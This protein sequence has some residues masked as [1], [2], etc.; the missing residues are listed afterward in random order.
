MASHRSQHLT[1][2]I[3][4]N[5]E[6]LMERILHYA[7]LHN[8]TAYTSTLMEAWRA[9]ISGLSEAL[10]QALASY[11]NPPE[12]G[13]TEDWFGDPCGI[14]GR[15]EADLHRS[16][17]ITLSMFLSLMK[18]YRQTYLDLL[19]ARYPTTCDWETLF[20]QRFFDRV[21]ISFVES[22]A[23]VDMTQNNVELQ[24][25]NR[26]LANEKN[27]F[28][29]LFE[30]SSLPCFL[31]TR[32]GRV[33]VMNLAAVRF[34][35][36][37]TR[38][39]EA[40]YFGRQNLT[41]PEWLADDIGGFCSSDKS[42]FEFEKI[43]CS[44]GQE[45]YFD[46]LFKRML[47]VSQKFSGVVV[48]LKDTTARVCAQKKLEQL[49]SNLKA[50]QAQLLQRE[51]MASIGQLATG[52]AHEI[53]NPIGF[54]QSNL[55][56]LQRYG[57]KLGLVLQQTEALLGEGQDTTLATRY[58]EIL[59]KNR[60]GQVLEDMPSLIKESLE[61]TARV[62]TIVRNLKTFSRVDSDSWGLCD[63]NE[64]LESTL[65]I[66]WNELKY[67]AEIRRHYGRLEAV[68]CNPQLISQVFL[69]L[70]I[71]AGQA[72]GDKGTISLTT[73]QDDADSYITIAD[74]GC[75][76][77][78]ETKRRLFEP[79]Y[80]TKEVGQGTGLGMSIVYDIV[81][82]HHGSIIVDSTLGQG[83]S[84]TIRLPK[85]AAQPQEGLLQ[86]AEPG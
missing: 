43:F 52:V 51:K 33:D 65:S 79:F 41:V 34:F 45:Y 7:S 18:Y 22:W 38:P 49:H 10:I 69:N 77:T 36:Q 6:W 5:E 35:G 28:L 63:L 78:E 11:D 13:P 73:W 57:E 12:F 58:A 19:Q 16:R 31:V 37:G 4:D 27:K 67:K 59:G 17:G 66:V 14:F 44:A 53:N 60:I 21:E 1:E 46:I 50:T 55:S 20:V 24:R 54:V 68:Y 47:D 62:A 56:S 29:T 26:N 30:S 72:L 48:T 80:T 84:F 15:H 74:T 75:G 42:E 64:S 83:S 71:N 70:L 32:D 61:G 3:R 82:T 23:N 86:G 76:M 40:Y 8:Y 25:A 81:S 2:L 39:G 9:S 85:R